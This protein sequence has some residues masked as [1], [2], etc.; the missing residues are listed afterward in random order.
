MSNKKVLCF[1][2]S[3]NRQKFLRGAIMDIQNQ[4]YENIVHSINLAGDN[5]NSQKLDRIVYD[6]LISERVKMVFT[7]NSHQHYNHMN[8]IMGVENYEDFDIFV[9]IDDDDIYKKNYI[10]NIVDF[11]ENNDVDMVSSKIKY[12]LN[13][14][15]IITGN[16]DNLGGNPKN[17]DFKMPFTFAFNKKALSL[18]KNLTNIFGFEDNM[19]R[20]SWCNRIKIM[21][22]DNK[23]NENF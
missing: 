3:Y 2:T 12:L 16:Y 7:K 18:I 19:W 22:I 1:T 15:K 4:T 14:S 13:G 21:E 9:K 5:E 11:F 10:K 23:D 20:E 6:D 8:A 17:C